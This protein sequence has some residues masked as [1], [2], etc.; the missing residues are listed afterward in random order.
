MSICWSVVLLL[1]VQS[2]SQEEPLRGQREVVVTATRTERERTAVPGSVSVVTR[3]D[4]Q[5]INVQDLGDGLE[6]L[7]GLKVSRYGGLG[8]E[9]SVHLRGLYGVHTLVLV[10]GRPVNFPS[11]SSADLS[12]LSIGNVERIEVVRGASSALY[13]ADA[14]GGV[15]QVFTAAPPEDLAV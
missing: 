10:D 7:A 15:V 13:G 3:G 11:L 14:V 2:Q 12:W 4:L 1:S 5:G 6:G 9:A 8:S